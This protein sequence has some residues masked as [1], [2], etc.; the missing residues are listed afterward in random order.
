MSKPP[1]DYANF[2]VKENGNYLYYQNPVKWAR[3]SSEILYHLLE[4]DSLIHLVNHYAPMDTLKCFDCIYSY[5]DNIFTSSD[6]KSV[7]YTDYYSY[8]VS[9]ILNC[10]NILTYK[11]I[12]PLTYSIPTKFENNKCDKEFIAY[13]WSMAMSSMDF[14]MYTV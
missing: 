11:F 2:I 13:F 9:D 6:K 3:R 10:N 14:L 1:I 7:F 5:N 8:E 12:L 4:Y